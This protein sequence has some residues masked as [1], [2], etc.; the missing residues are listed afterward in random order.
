MHY[1]LQRA[2]LSGVLL[3]LAEVIT[4]GLPLQLRALRE[5]LLAALP[6]LGLQITPSYT[7]L[8][9]EY[10]L[11]QTSHA[12]FLARL[13]P[14]LQDWQPPALDT[15]QAAVIEIPVFYDLT[16]GP[17]LPRVAE[18]AGLTVDA[19]ITLHAATAYEVCA[20]G[21]APGFAYLASVPLALRTPRLTTPRSRVP[22]GSVALAD[23]QTAV[24]PQESPGGWNLIGRTP[25]RM[26]DAKRSPPSVLQPGQPVRFVPVDQYTFVQL[27][28]VLDAG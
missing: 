7:S 13:H 19:V 14:L 4:P 18:Q 20:L 24:Y 12:A 5:Y 15:T 23:Q 11:L 22:A 1:E 3:Q 16:T 6:D 21:F 2:G 10:D 9:L 17:D 28:G 26:F 25:L 27:G 8:L